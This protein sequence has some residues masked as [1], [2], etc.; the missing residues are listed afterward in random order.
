MNLGCLGM[1]AGLGLMF[2][3]G[4]GV[5]DYFTVG[6]KQ[7]VTI[8]ELIE[9]G[10]S[11]G[12]YE[13]TGAEWNEMETLYQQDDETRRYKAENML[14]LVRPVGADRNEPV[15]VLLNQNSGEIA[16]KLSTTA[17]LDALV[18]STET[19]MDSVQ[20]SGEPIDAE[21]LQSAIEANDRLAETYA[22]HERAETITGRVSTSVPST[23]SRAEVLQT[24]GGQ[25]AE[26]FVTIDPNYEPDFW[27]S[28][29][30][31]GS[32]LVLLIIIGAF[33]MART[34]EEIE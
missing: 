3:G 28:A 25:V 17:T 13:I 31:F 23:W 5:Y 12:W 10:P 8:E 34:T 4:S 30:M 32:G 22:E 21:R 16:L 7:S 27:G 24:S 1:L 9:G 14:V 6:E 15:Q 29:G 11:S 26:N 33:S 19:Y 20:S 18:Q 2:F